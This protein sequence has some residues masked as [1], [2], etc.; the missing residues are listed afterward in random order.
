MERSCHGLVSTNFGRRELKNVCASQIGYWAELKINTRHLTADPAVPTSQTVTDAANSTGLGL[1]S[2]SLGGIGWHLL[3]PRIAYSAVLF[4]LLSLAAH[5][6]QAQARDQEQGLRPQ[7]PVSRAGLIQAASLLAVLDALLLGPLSPPALIS[8]AVQSWLLLQLRD[9][10]QCTAVD[11]SNAAESE[12]D[13]GDTN[14][15]TINVLTK[16][17]SSEHRGGTP[18]PSSPPRAGVKYLVSAGG[19]ASARASGGVG[20]GVGLY[21]EVAL[22]TALWLLTGRQYFFITGHT[23]AFAKIDVT[24]SFVGFQGVYVACRL[25]A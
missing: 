1:G 14:V 9:C 16:P 17:E 20:M 23:N 19:H 4:G 5:H 13:W 21:G 10:L 2:L 12:S 15:P 3:L 6:C 7:Q 8:M 24:A 18:A 11:E 25:T 22:F